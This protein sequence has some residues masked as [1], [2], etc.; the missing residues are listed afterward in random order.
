MRLDKLQQIEYVQHVLCREWACNPDIFTAGQNTI[1]FSSQDFFHMCSFG[2]HIIIRAG[3]KMYP[4]AK[5]RLALLPARDIM[6]S[7]TLFL[8]E[9]KLREYGRSLTGEHLR[10]LLLDS[11][12]PGSPD[13][14]YQFRHFSRKEIRD[15]YALTANRD[16]FRNALN[17]R[18][19]VLGFAAFFGDK[20]AALA[21]AD[22]NKDPLWQIGIDTLPAHRG[23][24]LGSF[25]V[26]TLAEEIVKRDKIPFYTTWSANL[27]SMHVALNAGFRPVWVEYF[28]E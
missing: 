26:R 6:D 8:I 5:E 25:L 10:F 15:L 14:S 11:G 19:D 13:A 20:L 16:S 21:A 28:S 18:D 17:F 9:A 4:W 2:E 23:K 1:I 27:L 3:E 24:G 12:K 22:D 7:E